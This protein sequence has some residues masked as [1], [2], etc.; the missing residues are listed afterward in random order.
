MLA[1]IVARHRCGP[2]GAA[3]VLIGRRAA[4]RSTAQE[5]GQKLVLHALQVGGLVLVEFRI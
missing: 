2:D 1:G 3:S 5:V 4:E